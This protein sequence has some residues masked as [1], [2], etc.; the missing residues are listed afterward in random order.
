MRGASQTSF[1][2]SFTV[3]LSGSEKTRPRS[4]L[5]RNTTCLQINLHLINPSKINIT[6]PNPINTSISHT[7]R[8]YSHLKPQ[9][10]ILTFLFPLFL[11]HPISSRCPTPP[12]TQI[13]GSAMSHP[14]SPP[15]LAKVL[16][17]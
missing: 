2:I 11:L 4:R 6:S 3:R 10:H 7:E 9:R 17:W 15:P 14:H 13:P 1:I 5:S 8:T 12:L 16:F